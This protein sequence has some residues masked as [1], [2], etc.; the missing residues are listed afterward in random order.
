MLSLPVEQRLDEGR[1][2]GQLAQA[3]RVGAPGG[4]ADQKGAADAVR[5]RGKFV[6]LLVEKTTEGG[7]APGKL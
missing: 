2:S 6:P 4:A 1:G 7:F 5:Q 3:L